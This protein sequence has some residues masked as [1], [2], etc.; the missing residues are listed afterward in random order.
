MESRFQVIIPTPRTLL[1]SLDEILDAFNTKFL[2]LAGLVDYTLSALL[3]LYCNT[4]QM[5]RIL[6]VV[7]LNAF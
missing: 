3:G 1:D 2:G 6:I 7:M 5:L 4:L